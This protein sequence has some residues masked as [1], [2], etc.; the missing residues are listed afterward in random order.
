MA[1]DSPGSPA[2]PEAPGKSSIYTDIA[3]WSP[4]LVPALLLVL[5]LP[6]SARSVLNQFGV[7]ACNFLHAETLYVLHVASA[8]N[9]CA[10]TVLC[11]QR[12]L[13]NPLLRLSGGQAQT[14]QANRLLQM[15]LPHHFCCHLQARTQRRT[16]CSFGRAH[17]YLHPF[18]TSI[19]S[20]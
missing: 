10:C 19:T 17:E 9:D 14:R 8:I 12:A 20:H 11:L 7:S 16:Q 18:C 13:Q 15:S 5:L 3:A 6:A 4:T 2:K 1:A